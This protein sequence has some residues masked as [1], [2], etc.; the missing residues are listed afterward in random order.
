MAAVLLVDEL[1]L[2]PEDWP[3]QMALL[4]SCAVALGWT[5]L[6]LALGGPG[7]DPRDLRRIGLAGSLLLAAGIGA[8]FREAYVLPQ[9]RP[10]DET[11]VMDHVSLREFRA[12]RARL[13]MGLRTVAAQFIPTGVFL[14]SL[15][16]AAPGLMKM[17]G[18][19]WQRYPEAVPR[20]ERGLALPEA[21]AGDLKLEQEVAQ[22]GEVVQQ[23]SFR[24]VVR[25]EPG[26]S[27][28]YPFDW[29]RI[30]LRLW[31]RAIYRSL[32]LVPDLWAYS[33]LTPTALPGV[34]QE[35]ALPGWSLSASEFAF[36]DASYNTNFGI[37]DFAGQRGSP[38]LVFNLALRRHFLSPFIAAF[39][40][41]GAVAGLLFIVLLTITRDPERTKNTGYNYLN[42]LR[43]VIALF[44]SLIVAQ[45]NVRAR[46]SAPGVLDLEWFYFVLYGLILLISG[47]ALRHAQ[48]REGVL[49]ANDQELPKLAFWPLLL[50]IYY[51]VAVRFLV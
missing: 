33:V 20:E 19:I 51:G 47:L 5:V 31:P 18:Q 6:I 44:F 42:L 38:E 16:A 10:A 45:F 23:Y 28:A 30:R 1:P 41:L 29:T 22:G 37:R 4:I 17:T 34:D 14:Q 35:V 39:L 26:K 49:H 36:V 40:P 15:E 50:W 46:I 43:T 24:A 8:L 48:G 25:E 7:L 3:R 11:V 21:L 9:R 27:G 32:V 2:R 12:R 13:Q